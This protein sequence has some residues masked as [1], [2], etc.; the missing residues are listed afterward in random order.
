MLP[1]SYF[2]IWNWLERIPKGWYEYRKWTPKKIKPRRGDILIKFSCLFC[3]QKKHRNGY[4]KFYQGLTETQSVKFEYSLFIHAAVMLTK[5]DLKI[6]CRTNVVSIPRFGIQHIGVKWHRL[7]L[8]EN[9]VPTDVGRTGD[10]PDECRDALA[11]W[12]DNPLNIFSAFLL[13][14]LKFPGYC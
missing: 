14:N 13:L 11:N 3:H 5:A 4:K 10:L 1:E 2:I 8:V 12:A 6:N 7:N 9:T